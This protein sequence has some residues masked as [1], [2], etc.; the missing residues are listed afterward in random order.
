MSTIRLGGEKGM[1][2]SQLEQWIWGHENDTGPLVGI[3]CAKGGTVGTFDEDGA[4]PAKAPT[5]ILDPEGKASCPG[6]GKGIGGRAYISGVC[7]KVLVCH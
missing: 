7:V 4:T 3:D 2:K 6:G 1:S 5:V